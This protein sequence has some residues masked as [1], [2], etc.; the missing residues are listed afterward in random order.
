M[1]RED[2]NPRPFK[3]E[4][5]SQASLGGFQDSNDDDEVHLTDHRKLD[6]MAPLRRRTT[7]QRVSRNLRRMSVRVVNLGS[8]GVDE[9][10]ARLADAHEE[11]E[12]PIKPGS[13]QALTP[14]RGRT[15]GFLG[16]R[17]PVR[18]ALYKSLLYQ[19][20]EPFILCLILFNA[21][22]LVIQSSRAL[23]L[24]PNQ[25]K[26]YF[27]GW[28]D[29]V[30]FTLFIFYTLEAFARI[31]VNGLV[32][33]PETPITAISFTDVARQIWNSLFHPKSG[34]RFHGIIQQIVKPF[35]LRKEQPVESDSKLPEKSITGH[36]QQPSL[37]Y[38][39]RPLP[40]VTAIQKERS[41]IKR[42]LPYLRHSW[43]RID[44]VAL[45]GFWIAFILSVSGAERVVTESSGTAILV[46]HIGLFRALSVLRCARLLAVTNGTTT[47]MQSL[48]MAQ[49]LL[50][51]VAYF[52][53]FAMILF[54]VIGVQSFKGS[55]RRECVFNPDGPE[56]IGLGQ[57]CGGYIHPDNLTT[58]GFIPLNGNSS[59]SYVKGFVCPLGQTCNEMSDNPMSNLESYD[60]IFYAALQVVV[61]AS[62]N[63]WAPT[64][65]SMIDSEFF[66]SSVFFIVCIVVLNFWLINLFV[67]V[68]TNTFQAIRS[69]T[70]KS[71]FGATES[72]KILAEDREGWTI[73]D[74][75]LSLRDNWMRDAYQ[76]TRLVWPI[77]AVISLG[78]A[79]SKTAKTTESVARMLDN[80]ELGITIAFDL[81]IIWRFLAHFPDWRSFGGGVANWADLIIAVGCSIIQIPPIHDSRAYPWLTVFQLFRWY[82]VILQ[83]PRM[84]P[85]ILTVFGN[86]S[87]LLNMTIFLLITNGL[88]ALAA[89][90]LL[91]GDLDNSTNMN[92]SQIWVAFLAMYQVLSSENW[93]DVMYG[94]SDAEHPTAMAW[95]TVIFLSGW[96]LFGN[97]IL[98]QLFIAVINENFDFAEEK[99][100]EQQVAEH[101]ANSQTNLGRFAW[102]SK[103][104]PYKYAKSNPKAIIV[105]NLPSNLVLPMQKVIVN[106]T[107]QRRELDS[108][109]EETEE[110]NKW[111]TRSIQMLHRLFSG[112]RRTDDVPLS[113]LSS[114]GKQ[115]SSPLE[116]EDEA[117]HHLD[118]LATFG[119]DAAAA[120]DT[121]N[122][123]Q[124]QRA[125]KADFIAAHPSYD[126]TFWVFSQNNPLRRACQ[127]LVEP[128]NGERIFG[129]PASQT[130]HALF[131]FTLFLAVIGGIIVAAIATPVYRRQY[132]AQNGP[133][134]GAWFTIA[135]GTFA[136]FLLL[137]FIIKIIADG[138]IFT[139]N[140]YL[141][142]IWNLVDLTILVGLLVNAVTSV[143]FLGGLSRLTRS[144]KAL[145][146]LRLITL[147]DKMRTTFH[148]LLIVGFVRIIDAAIL[149]GLY[150]IPYAV[151]G[152]NI[153][154][155]LSFSCNDGGNNVSGKAAC[156]NEYINNI[157]PFNNDFGFLAPRVWDNPTTSTRWSFDNFGASLLILFEIVSLEGWIDVMSAAVD[158]TGRDRQPSINAAQWNAL[159]FLIY[160]L[161]GAV[162]ILTLFVS[163]IIGNFSSRSGLALLTKPQREWIDLLKLIKRQR[164]SKRP[165]V[166]PTKGLRAWCF[167]RATSKHGYWMTSMTMLY[168]LHIIILMTQTFSNNRFSDQT[169]DLVFLGLSCIYSV[170]ICVRFVGLGWE[171]F[172]ANGWNIFDVIVV[173]GSIA[174]TI[175]IL[176]GSKGFVIQQ[177]QKL[178]LVSIAFKLV[179]RNNSLNQLFKTSISSLPVILSLL[180]LWFTLFVF[181][182]I[183][184]VEVFGLTRW[185]SAETHNENYTSLGR[186]LVM[187]AFMTTGEGWNQ[188]MHD[189]AVVYP[190]CTNPS[191][192]DPDSDC[193]SAG[194]AF[195]LFISWN[196]LSM[197]IFVNMFTGVVVENFSY[198]FQ[199][200]GGAKSV[201]REQ[202][203]AF[204]KVW[205]EFANQR[206]GYLERA[207]FV[208][209][210]GKLSGVFEV[211]IYPAE[212]Q[213]SRL[214]EAAA[215]A[216]DSDPRSISPLAENLDL[217]RLQQSLNNLDPV[218]IRQRRMLYNR[219]YH[220]AKLSFER[221][222]GI[223][224]TNMLL[225]LAHNKLI[226]DKEALSVKEILARQETMKMVSDAVNLDKVKTL[227]K[228]IYHRRRFLRLREE[229]RMSNRVDIP[230]IVVDP[231]MLP[232]G[233]A[234]DVSQIHGS[235]LSI[236]SPLRS[237]GLDEMLQTS[238]R[239]WSRR[240]SDRSMLGETSGR[241]S[242]D[243]SPS[244][245]HSVTMDR[246]EGFLTNL[247]NSP[248]KDLMA[249]TAEDEDD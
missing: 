97:F 38:S 163:I 29:Y 136:L 205:A 230:H 227:L 110:S 167:D 209:F 37:G 69:Q 170:D 233:E 234:E 238:E 11:D 9:G 149:A 94:A 73:S 175:P 236:D 92:F 32:L 241:Y 157:D 46:R 184:Y 242:R 204:K 14:L 60:N 248:W 18:V 199:L 41:L 109:A 6:P 169:R 159:F 118:I 39:H 54:S 223:S 188:Y 246:S 214:L 224:F 211:R 244:P 55:F 206:T 84:R 47:I 117:S 127:A 89:V 186:A 44:F 100:R 59:T 171:S 208:P 165:K 231:D 116:E 140:A 216:E 162:V 104:N 23:F 78:L 240:Y 13:V 3:Y 158:I 181:F 2:D 125:R 146:A 105:E 212:Y 66:I 151:W 95:I 143:I 200:A 122:I 215:A 155:G 72:E 71:A 129:R 75:K 189:Y 191:E 245:R 221:G 36:M 98:I 166:R 218:S 185:E 16:P 219:L 187:L 119:A 34:H 198:V 133:V 225:M 123:L 164:P 239:T 93:T 31:C 25:P 144:L 154:A 180:I 102:I 194:W 5:P 249:Q 213:T 207:N 193:G 17:N 19:Y 128:P 45:L 111:T 1:F 86:S 4:F 137:E 202:M 65:Y 220:E 142:S 42:G 85:L 210:F 81:E 176:A 15:L 135:E 82:R 24:D 190:R 161:L 61:I 177:L 247:E 178:F 160:N 131:Q 232:P 10:H 52:V 113:K 64:M 124:E 96:F 63:T 70:N 35:A 182:G 91:R 108:S 33:D 237:Q 8:A 106:N 112:E 172:R 217:Y 196:I 235:S 174:T 20:T 192:A 12:E 48:K 147:F 173:T 87:G 197:Y 28:E 40:F 126:K 49:P 30:L 132:Y 50:A 51:Q 107:R 88:A 7:L 152:L 138:F 115:E 83:V 130:A 228:M 148:S 43:S 56:P 22:I 74:N 68:I 114:S 77:L 27:Q 229:R 99:K 139:P 222:K 179:Q 76:L 53:L 226:T 103:L 145:R 80:A 121:D 79:A 101:L 21:V 57:Q 201:D 120:E 58:V 26:G 243:A 183:L 134:R 150:I 62:A 90:Q 195:F 168:I 141:L 153:F 203:R 156:Q 67:A